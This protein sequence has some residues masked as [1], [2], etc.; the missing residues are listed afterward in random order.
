M[1]EPFANCDPAVVRKFDSLAFEIV[2]RN[3][4][5]HTRVYIGDTFNA[6]K[7]N[8]GF[9][10]SQKYEGTFLDSHYYHVFD[11][12]PRHLSPREHI[13][14][15]CRHNHHD[16]VSCC[17]EDEG[18]KTVPAKGIS[19]IIGEWSA[20][21]DTLVCDKLDEV[22]SGIAKNGEQRCASKVD[23]ILSRSYSSYIM[24]Y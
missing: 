1:N 7:W 10:K 24:W 19:R 23:M 11:E 15:V 9:W 20:S 2:R 17:Y 21:F 18:N 22:M 6:S 4:G 8:D 16:T 5:R 3:M 14:L 12:R 13:A